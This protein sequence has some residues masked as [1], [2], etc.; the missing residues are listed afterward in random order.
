VTI[1]RLEQSVGWAWKA[2]FL[3]AAAFGAS[4]LFIIDRIDD[5][6]EANANKLDT[7]ARD[8]T[9]DISDLRVSV[10]EARQINEQRQR[11]MGQVPEPVE[12]N[13]V[14]RAP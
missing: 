14:G 6:F 8:I 13:V 2:I 10:V 12:G 11:V 9:K 7:I 1:G 4:F 5:K 3:L